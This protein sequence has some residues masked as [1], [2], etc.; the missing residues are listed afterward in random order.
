[1]RI[2]RVLSVPI[3]AAALVLCALPAPAKDFV[4]H[5]GTLLDGLAD[6]PRLQVSILIR[7]DRVTAVQSGYLTPPGAEI[8]DLKDATVMPGFIDCHVH[9]GAL[10]PNTTNA[11][12]YSVTHSDIDRALDDVVFVRQMLQQGF[13]SARDVGG[14]DDTV[15][16]RKAIDAGKIPGP[17]LWVSLEPLGPTAGHG[18]PRTGLDPALSHT[19]WDNGI[20]D[21]PDQAR[22]RVRQHQGRGATVIKL[23]PSGGIASTG[24]DPRAQLMTN[25]EMRAAVETAHS[26]G[27]KV[28]AHIYPA[29]AIENAVRAGVD[30]VEHGSFATAQTFALMKAHGTYLVPTLS[31]YDVFY[32][33]ARDHPELLT[34]GTP[35][36]ELA[37]DLLPKRNLPLAIRSGVKIAYGTDLGQG[38]HTMEFGLLVANGMSPLQALYAATRNAAELLGAAD[39]LGSVQAGRLADLVATR[40]NPLEQPEAFKHVSFVMKGGVVYRHDDAESVAVPN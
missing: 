26:L 3:M 28:A 1:M 7:D 22:L 24:D 33:T 32:A 2:A 6:A 29:E 11:T 27:L 39:R 4:I 17:R 31:V 20:V 13:T 36:K 10:L 15:S 5:A 23:M 21:S 34:P 16:V 9:I 14:G 8:I 30:S 37:N 12:A 25:E 18:D 40:V 19:G 35:A 38:D